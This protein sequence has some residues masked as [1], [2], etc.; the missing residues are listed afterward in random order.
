MTILLQGFTFIRNR[1]SKTIEPLYGRGSHAGYIAKTKSGG[2]WWRGHSI[3]PKNFRLDLQ[4]TVLSMCFLR[5]PDVAFL[6]RPNKDNAIVRPS[7]CFGPNALRI[8]STKPTI[9]ETIQAM[10]P[11]NFI[12]RNKINLPPG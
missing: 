3:L 4:I 1:S 5:R 9:S 6:R 8:Q 2:Q 12:E 7:A 11:F 10:L